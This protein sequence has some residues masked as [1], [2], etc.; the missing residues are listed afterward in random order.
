MI[1]DHQSD[2]GEEHRQQDMVGGAA[3]EAEIE[4]LGFWSGLSDHDDDDESWDDDDYDDS[5]EEEDEEE[6][7]DD[8]DD[9]EDDEGGLDLRLIGHI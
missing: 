8:D 3:T 6:D 1:D 4:E 7:D 2:E 5:E 9:D